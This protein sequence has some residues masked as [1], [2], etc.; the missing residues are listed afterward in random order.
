[1]PVLSPRRLI[2]TL[3]CLL[4]LF[5]SPLA[6]A[7]L[8]SLVPASNSST[9]L[10]ADEA[11]QLVPAEEDGGLFLDFRVTPGHYLYRDRFRFDAVSGDL[12]IG[13]PEFSAEG[14]WEDDPTF[15]RVRV[16][17]ESMS[18]VL[19]VKGNGQ[20]KVTWQGCAD[21]G[22]CYPP[23]DTL[24]PVGNADLSAIPAP[25]VTSG[26]SPAESSTN[27]Y[28]LILLFLLG[29]GLTFTPCVLPML[30][31][32][33]S[34]VARQHTRSAV[35]GFSL[36][37]A[38][39]LGMASVY[40]LIGFLAGFMGQQINLPAWFQQPA[41]LVTFAIIFFALALSLFGVFELR[42]PSVISNYF[43]QKTRQQNGGA[44]A[45]TYLIGVFSALVVSPCV[46][47][48]LF[49]VLLHV[50]ST[51]NALYGATA[52]FLMALGMGAP[53]LILGATEGRLLP[54]AGAWMNEVKTFFGLL[55]LFVAAELLSRLLPP[56]FTLGL[57]GLCTAATGFWLWQLQA[58]HGKGIVLFRTLGFSILVYA[59][60]LLAGAA[61]GGD[62]PLKPLAQFSSQ[63]QAA[64][65]TPFVRIKSIADLDREREV[66][67]QTGKVLMFD[68]YADWCVS[69]KI[70]ERH[71]FRQPEIAERL[72]RL[73]L[74]QADVTANDA[75]DR[76]LLK[77]YALLGPPT[78]LFFDA[79][80]NE[81]SKARL[82]GEKNARDFLAHLNEHGL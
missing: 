63:P 37:L 3:L 40:A 35:R 30:P 48:P 69:C 2:F 29:L 26:N 56:H 14:E 33:A 8:K 72:S 52:L 78:L 7:G 60:V 15:G 9:F 50:S 74:V 34:I 54:R 64:T 79:Q 77:K 20:L 13:T 17:H 62:D 25:S 47:A 58:K 70:M 27:R 80:G 53:L 57:Y 76:E 43:D 28:S 55:L 12:T 5:A 66:A 6:S 18:I 68:L 49:G 32:L 16:Y 19:P 22:L 82:V 45:G 59:F 21:A 4:S 38:Y 39:V 46:S 71:V 67:R 61:S 24:V 65:S 41:L 23:Q 75:T 51:G 36:A 44:F 10:P 73:H 1:M 31:I 42:L 81:I 11:F